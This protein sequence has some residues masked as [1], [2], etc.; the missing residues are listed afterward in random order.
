MNDMDILTEVIRA[1]SGDEESLNNLFNQFQP[2][3]T[4]LLNRFSNKGLDN[5]DVRQQID[6]FFVEAVL[7]YDHNK[8]DSPLRHIISKTRRDTWTYYRKEMGYFDPRRIDDISAVDESD[9]SLVILEED[10]IIDSIILRD[11]I[12]KLPSNYQQV[13]KLYYFGHYTQEEIADMLSVNQSSVNR[14][15]KRALTAIREVLQQDDFDY[16]NA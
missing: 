15:L 6:M 13:I 16:D 12:N 2:F 10:D 14:T 8:D 5:D 3:R 11:A 7:S 1:Q 9:S 4:S